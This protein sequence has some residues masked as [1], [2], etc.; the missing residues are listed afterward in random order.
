VHPILDSKWRYLLLPAVF[1]VLYYEV[2]RHIIQKWGSP[3]GAH[4]PLILAVCFYLVWLKR[5]EI[6]CLVPKPELISG[7]LLLAAGCFA[8]FAGEIGSTILVQLV[9]MVPVLLGVALLIGGFSFFKAFLLPVGYLLFL[10]GFIEQL[11]DGIGIYLQKISA[12]ISALIFKMLGWPV[13]LDATVI[14]LPHISLEVVRACSGISHIVALM[15]LA[16]PLANLTQATKVRKI[17][18]ILSSVVIG[19]FANGLRV[20]LIGIYASYNEGVELHGPYETLYVSFIFFFG[21]IVLIL[22]SRILSMKDLNRQ[23]ADA[24]SINEQYSALSRPGGIPGALRKQHYAILI[25]A[26]LFLVTIGFSRFYIISPVE[27]KYPLEQ[28]PGDIAGFTSTE[29]EKMDERLH[30]FA[31]DVELLR[32]YEDI[33]GRWVE[34]YIGYFE[35][36]DRER[37]I[38]DYRRA[39]MHEESTIV[40]LEHGKTNVMINKTRLRDQRAPRDVYFW[41]ITDGRIIRGQY[42]GKLA[43]FMNGL[44][45]RRTNAGLVIISTQNAES[46]VMPLIAE[47]AEAAGKFLQ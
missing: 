31:A 30:P 12:W 14:Q 45:K 9:S 2:I 11:L 13:F 40:R 19:V 38:I 7:A 25:T 43:T 32:R 24:G 27:L 18:L 29:I 4:G 47:I 36:Q 34:L 35:M 5:Q 3:E 15:A 41:Y 16:V 42:A 46:E 22:F 39:W 23:T 33:E 1:F 20:A 6:R 44:L 28:F 8:F 21:L 10:T 17:I 37:K 26:A